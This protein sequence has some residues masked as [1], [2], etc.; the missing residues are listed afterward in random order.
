MARLFGQEFTTPLRYKFQQTFS[1]MSKTQIKTVIVFIELGALLL[2][3]RNSEV[4]IL[5]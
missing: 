4:H 5:Q 1:R 3:M 2:M